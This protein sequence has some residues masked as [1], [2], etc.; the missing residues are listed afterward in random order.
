MKIKNRRKPKIFISEQH[1]FDQFCPDNRTE[2]W[3]DDRLVISKEWHDRN[4]MDI[5][6]DLLIALKLHFTLKVVSLGVESKDK[7]KIYKF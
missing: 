3:V 6:E 7:E 5:I 4:E 1:C 2:I